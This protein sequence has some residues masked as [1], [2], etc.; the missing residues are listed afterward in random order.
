MAVKLIDESS[1]PPFMDAVINRVT[2]RFSDAWQAW[3]SRTPASFHAVPSV[4]NLVTLE[5][6]S[7]SISATDLPEMVLPAGVYRVSYYTRVTTAAG[8]SSSLTVTF[9]W[10][11]GGVAQTYSGAA[12]NGN[13]TTTYQSGSIVIRSDAGAAVTYATT[14]AS[15]PAS[16][17]QYSLDAFIEWV[18]E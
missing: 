1:P 18:R 16:A 6:Q 5:A 15:N 17:M 14:Y 11:D 12:M 7:A 8:V 9:A 13:T 3:L 2:G 10:T 4:L